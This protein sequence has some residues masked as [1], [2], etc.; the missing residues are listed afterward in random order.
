LQR[1]NEGSTERWLTG[2]TWRIKPTQLLKLE[3][4]GGS[5]DQPEAPRGF[6]ASYALFF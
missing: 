1:P 6:I 3:F 4:T 2:A 5:G